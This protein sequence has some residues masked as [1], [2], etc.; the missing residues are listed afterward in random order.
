MQNDFVTGTLANEE[1]AKIIGAIVAK[2]E[3]YQKDDHPVF[4][5]RDTHGEEYLETQEGKLPARSSLHKGYRG[6]AAC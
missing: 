1:A 3:S 6:L 2:I 5:T 4:F